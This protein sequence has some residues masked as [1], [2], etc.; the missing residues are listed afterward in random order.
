MRKYTKALLT[1][2]SVFSAATPAATLA[3]STN[4]DNNTSA[5]AQ[6]NRS[7]PKIGVS[8]GDASASNK[9]ANVIS[10]N[11]APLQVE[12]DKEQK[13]FLLNHALPVLQR[14]PTM[15]VVIQS[16]ARSN[17]KDRYEKTRIALARGLEIRQFFLDQGISP[18]RVRIQPLPVDGDR[19]DDDR[20]DLVFTY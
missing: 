2:L 6:A 16:L 5:P 9:A 12:L 19:G 13:A 11:L 15:N 17:P 8:L 18:K 14:D 4:I 20:V 1:I 10:F 3:Q 7:A